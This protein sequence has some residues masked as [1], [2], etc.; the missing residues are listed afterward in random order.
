MIL[1]ANKITAA[2]AGESYRF[3]VGE[4]GRPHRSVFTLGHAR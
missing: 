2:N 1:L 4:Q 3:G